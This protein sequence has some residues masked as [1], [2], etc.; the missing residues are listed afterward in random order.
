MKHRMAV[1]LVAGVLAF[2]ALGCVCGRIPFPIGLVR[3]SGDVVSETREIGDVTEVDLQSFGSVHIE[4][5]EQVSLRIEAE[6]NLLRYIETDTSGG[7]L[8]IKHR[9]GTRLMNTMPIDYYLTVRDLDGITVSG[10]GN[11]DAP[12]LR[13][14]RLAIRLSGAGNV[15]IESLQADALDA[16]ISGA[17]GLSIG[18]GAVDGQEVVITGA[19]DYRAR[20]LESRE[21]TVR[22]S[23]LG[24]ATVYARERLDVTIS[25]AGSVQYRGDPEVEQ[26]V[27][28]VGGVRRI[29]E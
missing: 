18:G 26:Q 15:Q 1:L 4:L 6:D 20:E 22:L 3:G 29:S 2:S 12:D 7:R 11:V 16:T 23:G 17:G 21:A 13:T 14:E 27:S 25:G 8:E 10:A 19:G 5:G 9:R 28:G 24:S